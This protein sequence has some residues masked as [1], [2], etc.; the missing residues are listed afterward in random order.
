MSVTKN[1]H[2]VSEGILKHFSDSNNKI[3]EMFIEKKCISKKS[4]SSVMSQN[5]VYEHP[6]IQK[7][8]IEDAFAN[9]IEAKVFPVMDK[10]IDVIEKNY[11]SDGNCTFCY[12]SIKNILSAIIVFYFRS[13]ALIHEYAFSSDNPKLD[14]VERM[15]TKICDIHY[16]TGLCETIVK[17]YDWAILIDEKERFLLSDQYLSTVALKYKNRFSN[18]SNRQIGMKNTML[19]LPLSAKIYVA[20]YS[21]R[22]PDFIKK[23]KFCILFDDQLQ[24]INNVIYENSYV[25]CVGKFENELMR[26]KSICEEGYSPSKCILKYNNGRIKDYIIKKEV[27]W[28]D[29]DKDLCRNFDQYVRIYFEKIKGKI[30]RNSLCICGS[31][32]KY[33]KCCMRKYEAIKEIIGAIRAPK[34]IDYN[35]PGVVISEEAIEEFF[36]LE[37]DLNN[38]S[39]REIL[40]KIEKMGIKY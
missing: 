13:G 4:I 40:R 6:L 10:L 3:Y 34:S 38:S 22:V 39:D 25:K 26:M 5:Y 29:E 28:Y 23:D 9:D 21:G 18:A 17:C 36:G 11:S 1:Q 30:E 8:A 7:N 19:L 31:G 2:Y 27:F 24:E 15:L 20:F 37:K 12:D 32:R 33:K 14:R 16:I 35:I